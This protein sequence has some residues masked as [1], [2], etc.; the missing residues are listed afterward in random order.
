M[1]LWAVCSWIC[2]LVGEVIF[3]LHGF[4]FSGRLSQALFCLLHFSIEWVITNTSSQQFHIFYKTNCIILILAVTRS[5]ETPSCSDPFRK[6][7]CTEPCNTSRCAQLH[8]PTH[9]SALIRIFGSHHQVVNKPTTVPDLITREQYVAFYLT[10]LFTVYTCVP[11]TEHH[12]K[13]S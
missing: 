6:R 1:K 10:C 5:L 9:A 2:N 4:L 11:C 7:L 8:V 12:N 13:Y 3:R